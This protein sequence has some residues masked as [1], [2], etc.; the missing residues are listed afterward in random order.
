M[1]LTD[2]TTLEKPR[3][4][5][6]VRFSCGKGTMWILGYNISHARRKVCME[7]LKASGGSVQASAPDKSSYLAGGLGGRT[8]TPG[9]A[10]HW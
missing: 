1:V 10:I 6:D 7:L 3:F 9:F 2:G 8:G 5:R 4:A